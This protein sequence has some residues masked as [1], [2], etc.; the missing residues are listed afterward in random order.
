MTSKKTRNHA[1]V[2]VDQ[3]V[4]W[5]HKEPEFEFAPHQISTAWP[6][7]LSLSLSGEMVYHFF[8][9]ERRYKGKEGL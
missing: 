4:P 7:E 3:D 9:R 8:L 6:P 5:I 1:S 2:S